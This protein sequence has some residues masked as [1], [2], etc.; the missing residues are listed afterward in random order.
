MSQWEPDKAWLD[1]RFRTRVVPDI[2]RGAESSSRPT[3]VL[4][5]AQPGA[6]KTRATEFAQRMNDAKLVA[7]T[8]DD[9]RSLH[10]DFK[11]LQRDDPHEMPNVTQAVS[12]P[13]VARAVEYARENRISVIVEGTF[14]DPQMVAQTV[15][16]FHGAGFSVH[17]VALAVPP[18]VSRASTLGR[19]YETLGTDQNR[20]TPPTAHEAAVKAMP[21]TVA[22]L[23]ASPQVDR[24][25]IVDRDGTVLA[26]SSR[27]GPE[28]AEQMGQLIEQAHSRPL[29]GQERELVDTIT[30]DA[31]SSERALRAAKIARVA[32]G[33]GKPSAT[34]PSSTIDPQRH[35][36]PRPPMRHERPPFGIGD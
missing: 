7:I 10:P 35:H 23:A 4:L 30:R 8:G 33:P 17:A 3:V 1:H 2:F 16:R 20:W 15:Q 27:P 32:M 14:R 6:G 25:S 31:E 26:D 21:H 9:F 29:T 28:S 34:S 19:F 13:M 5:G 11:R 18:E 24:F 12:G 22:A 36:R